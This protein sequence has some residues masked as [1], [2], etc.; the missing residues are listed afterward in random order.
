[1]D[2]SDNFLD[3][4]ENGSFDG[5]VSLQE[6]NFAYNTISSIEYFSFIDLKCLETLDLSENYLISFENHFF[7][8]LSK[9]KFLDLKSNLIEFISPYSF[10]Q[11]D[12]LE[13]IDLSN[14]RLH[15]I[16]NGMLISLPCQGDNFKT[17]F[18]K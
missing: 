7:R 17:S 13:S 8:G 14:N 11:N 12:L 2:L 5:L 10:I 9:I 4:I 1:M 3:K 16:K 6:L 18:F 15:E